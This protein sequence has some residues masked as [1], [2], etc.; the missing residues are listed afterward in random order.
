MEKAVKGELEEK[1]ELKIMEKKLM[2]E[3]EKKVELKDMEEQMKLEEKLIIG[4]I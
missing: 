4:I 2:K 1:A 3:L